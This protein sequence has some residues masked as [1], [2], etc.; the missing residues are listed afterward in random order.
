MRKKEYKA[1]TYGLRYK[2]YE[3][4]LNRK[5]YQ[6]K[7]CKGYD[8]FLEDVKLM[9]KGRSNQG[10]V[11]AFANIWMRRI[12][13]LDLKSLKKL[14]DEYKKDDMNPYKFTLEYKLDLYNKKMEEMQKNNKKT[15]KNEND[16]L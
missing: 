15:T 13:E 3:H 6:T 12:C 1:I 4:I 5:V 16:M 8:A 2:D 10:K 14:V 11:S 9:K 7:D